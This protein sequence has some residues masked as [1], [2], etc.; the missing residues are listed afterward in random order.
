MS[1]CSKQ[2]N[3]DKET[4]VVKAAI[5]MVKNIS[6]NVNIKRNDT[7]VDNTGTIRE[8]LKAPQ[9]RKWCSESS[10]ELKEAISHLKQGYLSKKKTKCL[11]RLLAT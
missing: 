6:S 9:Y 8:Q 3:K 7:D 5:P 10:S 1:N 2:H 11:I 4:Q